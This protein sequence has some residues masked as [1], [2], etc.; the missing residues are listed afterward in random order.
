MPQLSAPPTKD[1]QSWSGKHLFI[2][3]SLELLKSL[4]SHGREVRAK[5]LLGT[6]CYGYAIILESLNF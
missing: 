3:V 5:F 2:L 6:I 4:A 1:H